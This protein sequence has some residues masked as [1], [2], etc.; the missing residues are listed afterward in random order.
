L[1]GRCSSSSLNQRPF[2]TV[3]AERRCS[4]KLSVGFSYERLNGGRPS[5]YRRYQPAG[6][7]IS[8]GAPKNR[9]WV[10]G[11]EREGTNETKREK[12]KDTS[13]IFKCCFRTPYQKWT[14]PLP[15]PALKQRKQKQTEREKTGETKTVRRIGQPTQERQPRLRLRHPL[16]PPNRH[17]TETIREPRVN[18]RSSVSSQRNRGG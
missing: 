2:S 13:Q 18:F 12:P 3:K 5:A 16:S 9:G 11:L 10:E 14:L 6:L 17:D 4:S 8:R 7:Y 1:K 15:I